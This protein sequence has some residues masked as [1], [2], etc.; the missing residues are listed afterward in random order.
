VGVLVVWELGVQAGVIS[1]L[2]FPEPSLIGRTLSKMVAN[3]ELIGHI[4][5]TLRRVLWGMLLGCVPGLLLGLVMGRSVRVRGLVDP[6]IAAAHPLPKIALLPLIMVIFGVGETSLIIVAAAG[7]FFPLLIN[8]MSGVLGIPQLYFEV[9]HSYC[10]GRRKVLRRVVLPG[11]L[12]AILTG[13]R[14]AAN[15]T[16][17]VSVAV[18]M[19]SARQG[20][21]AMI[22]MA[23]NT[24]RTEEM[25]V[26]LLVITGMGVCIT[27]ALHALSRWIA[28]W[29]ARWSK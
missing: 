6:F 4:G 15:V 18:E 14:L 3:G 21:G 22:W 25:Y 11:S 16:L 2:Y 9:A 12:P 13:L 24:M 7:A 17:L 28:P 27:L 26:S 20:L 29:H 8:T 23:W 19:I 5:A 10:A 1:G